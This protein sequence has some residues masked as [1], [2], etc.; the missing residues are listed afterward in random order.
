MAT[1]KHTPGPWKSVTS[2]EKVL[3]TVV[4]EFG[5]PICQLH[6]GALN[7]IPDSI[8]ANAALIAAA[9]DLLEALNGGLEYDPTPLDWIAALVAD[10][11]SLRKAA[12]AAGI[13]QE[14]PDSEGTMLYRV[15]IFVKEARAAIAKAENPELSK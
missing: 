7:F 14:D 10:Y 11:E 8:E 5:D 12:T 6:N 9:P 3:D 2:T 4:N 1:T 13:E 15:H